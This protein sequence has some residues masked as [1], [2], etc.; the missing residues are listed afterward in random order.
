[1]RSLSRPQFDP[2]ETTLTVASKFASS[3]LEQRIGAAQ[4]DF[5]EAYNR[6]ETASD[7]ATWYSLGHCQHGIG[8]QVILADLTKDELGMLYSNGLVRGSREARDIY[9][10]IKVAARGRCPY[11]GDIGDVDPLDHYLPKSRYPQY[12]VV[13]ANLVPSCDRCNKLSGSNLAQTY[14]KQ[15]INPYFDHDRFFSEPWV[16]VQFPDDNIYGLIYTCEPP[17]HWS[18]SDQTRVQNHF[19]D[20]KLAER[21]AAAASSEIRYL[22]IDFVAL[23]NEVNDEKVVRNQLE[24][25]AFSECYL[26]NS[27]LRPL[28]RAIS[29]AKWYLD[30][31]K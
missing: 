20:F 1:M 31:F 27:W 19:E 24:S 7:T 29:Q 8:E 2:W 15:S 21:Y 10:Q 30:L 17:A 9:D 6:F 5:L 3:G 23:M 4:P 14:E 26:L 13:P 25:R 18:Q 11:C 16:S 22:A 12:S 28:Y